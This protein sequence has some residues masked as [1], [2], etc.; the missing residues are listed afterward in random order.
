MQVTGVITM[1]PKPTLEQV[2]EGAVTAP[3]QKDIGY[4]ATFNYPKDGGIGELPKRIFEKC[5]KE[6]FLFN[7]SSG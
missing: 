3:E 6:K 2:I 4:N 5:E 7:V 1:L